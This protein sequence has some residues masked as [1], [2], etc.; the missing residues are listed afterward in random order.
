MRQDHDEADKKFILGIQRWISDKH[1]WKIPLDTT[2]ITDRILLSQGSEPSTH[3]PIVAT[4]WTVIPSG[5]MIHDVLRS[6]YLACTYIID[7][8][9]TYLANE[10]VRS[11]GKKD[12]RVA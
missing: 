4:S 12:P 1:S 2:D 3:D 9:D 6:R 8:F 10:V 5:V 11:M 7:P